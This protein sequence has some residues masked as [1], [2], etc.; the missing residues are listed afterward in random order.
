MLFCGIES[1]QFHLASDQI[2]A[3]VLLFVTDI[4]AGK[5]A[6]EIHRQR[7]EMTI[8]S[9]FWKVLTAPFRGAGVILAVR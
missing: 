4:L 3:A 7:Q 2:P 9:S 5:T 1:I 8:S 6:I